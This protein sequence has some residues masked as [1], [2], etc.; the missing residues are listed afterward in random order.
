MTLRN[1]CPRMSNK[2]I[3]LTQ[4][5]GHTPGPWR[6]YTMEDGG[7]EWYEIKCADEPLGFISVHQGNWKPTNARLIAAVPDLIA[8]LK[9]CY[10]KIDA[11]T[12]ALE[13]IAGDLVCASSGDAIAEIAEYADEMS[14]LI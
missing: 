1:K 14:G 5:E 3:D 2:R 10:E 11:L 4:F 9:R 13:T 8:E 6:S 7:E 12:T